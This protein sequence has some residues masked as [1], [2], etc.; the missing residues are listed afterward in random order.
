V[1]GLNDRLGFLGA[2]LGLV[3]QEGYYCFPFLAGPRP[4][5]GLGWYSSRCSC[6]YSTKKKSILFCSPPPRDE[7]EASSGR[8][9][10]PHR[11]KPFVLLL[12]AISTSLRRAERTPESRPPALGM[13]RMS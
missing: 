3:A 1:R 12:P 13:S 6:V 2:S 10:S 8:E 4:L 11:R 9:K 5:G 7:E